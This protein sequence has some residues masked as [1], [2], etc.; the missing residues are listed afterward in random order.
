MSRPAI[1][2]KERLARRAAGLILRA[3]LPVV[4]LLTQSPRAGVRRSLWSGSPILNM[5]VNAR[6]EKLLGVRADSLV[7]KTYYI[8]SAFRYNLASWNRGPAA[9]RLFVFPILV[10]LWAAL[11]YQR[12]HFYCD[13][14]LLPGEAFEFRED[15]LA[16]L[17]G[18]GKQLFFHTYGA[19]VRTRKAT[20]ALG[21]PNCCT[22]CPQPGA[23]CVCD[24]DLQ[25][26]RYAVVRRYATQ[27]F[28]MG[29]MIH[30]TPG[31]RND[32]FFWPVDLNADGGRRY[33]PQYPDPVGIAPVRI[34][35][36]PNHQGFK[37]TSYLVAAIERLKA[38]GIPVEFQLVER[39]PNREALE[40]Y[41][42]ADIIFDQCLI[43]YHGYFAIEGMAL[44]KAVVVFLRH[45]ELYVPAPAECPLVNVHRDTIDAVLEGLVRDRQRLH[46]IGKRGRT[47]VE[48][49]FSLE[50]F[51][52]RLRRAY[53]ELGLEVAGS[54]RIG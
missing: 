21:E 47:Y 36:A 30:Y 50:A 14:G 5:A 31:S 13:R 6:A 28:S 41:R 45:P 2:R 37:G 32:L 18:L 22:H 24:D 43:G 33:V 38:R 39:V 10:L 54:G 35:H 53:E 27:V 34:V 44:G 29:D 8:T 12:F 3:A 42:Q 4:R 7:Y 40:I 25:A 52:G 48:R 26:R 49:Y 15:E 1:S 9:W 20:Q 23:C 51:A 11:R 19:D 46:E 16:F 17:R